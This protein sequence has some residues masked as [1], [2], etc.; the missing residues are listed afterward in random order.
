M[1]CDTN[2]LIAYLNGEQGIAHM[3]H[4][5]K[6]Q[7]YISAITVIEVLAFPKL[8]K[9]EIDII[10]AF[11][12]SFEIVDLD[13]KLALDAAFLCRRYKLKA[14]DS[15]IAATGLILGIPLA[16]RDKAF[17]KVKNLEVMEM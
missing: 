12:Q 6:K 15:I 1:L 11:L 14:P 9:Q 10:Q 3:L 2:I 17:K 7:L 16:T 8:S 5:S 4:D 13:T